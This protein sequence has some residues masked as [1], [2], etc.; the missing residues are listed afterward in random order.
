MFV[1]AAQP[2]FSFN[3]QRL[4]GSVLQ[5]SV[6]Y[7]A[8]GWFAGWWVHNFELQSV[9]SITI[10]P[11]TLGFPTAQDKFIP[12]QQI[13]KYWTVRFSESSLTF[14]FALE[15]WS[16][17]TEGSG[18][19]TRVNN[20]I[21]E[22]KGTTTG[23]DT[24]DA[25]VNA[26]TG[27][28]LSFNS[29][30]TGMAASGY[31][32]NGV[33]NFEVTKPYVFG[34]D[35]IYIRYGDNL[36]LNGATYAYSFDGTKHTWDGLFEITGNAVTYIGNTDYIYDAAGSEWRN[37]GAV[38]EY[39]NAHIQSQ[40]IF[41]VEQD[42]K[43]TLVGGYDRFVLFSRSNSYDT[44]I[45]DDYNVTE[46]TG[47]DDVNREMPFTIR[48]YPMPPDGVIANRTWAAW[49][50]AGWR[51]PIWIKIG[52]KFDITF[53]LDIYERY[54]RSPG[55]DGSIQSYYMA[56]LYMRLKR[57][58]KNQTIQQKIDD[59]DVKWSVTVNGIEY[60]ESIIP[61]T[62][63]GLRV[64]LTDKL[65]HTE[66]QT[67]WAIDLNA[68]N[69]NADPQFP[70]PLNYKYASITFEMFAQIPTWLEIPPPPPKWAPP[71]ETYP[72]QSAIEYPG[73][74]DYLYPDHNIPA[75]WK[76]PVTY[77]I[78]WPAEPA[79][80]K[81][82]VI[83]GS[84]SWP[85][86]PNDWKNPVTIGSIAWPTTAPDG[87]TGTTALGNDWAS[88]IATPA[89]YAGNYVAPAD[90]LSTT[91]SYADFIAPLK[92]ANWPST[93]AFPVATIGGWNNMPYPPPGWIFGV[94]D[95]T[96]SDPW[97][98]ASTT[99][100]QLMA[101]NIPSTWPITMSFPIAQAAWDDVPWPPT[102][103]FGVA[104]LATNEWFDATQTY[105]QFANANKPAAWPLRWADPD[106]LMWPM[107]PESGW[108]PRTITNPSYPLTG[109]IN[110][111]APV[112]WT[113][114][115]PIRWP[116]AITNEPLEW[117]TD[118]ISY[119]D[120]VTA[121][122]PYQAAAAN[123]NTGGDPGYMWPN[124]P[125]INWPRPVV[126]YPVTY[127]GSN[128]YSYNASTGQITFSN[129]RPPDW[130]TFVTMDVKSKGTSKEIYIGEDQ[131]TPGWPLFGGRDYIVLNRRSLFAEDKNLFTAD[132]EDEYKVGTEIGALFPFCTYG[133]MIFI[134]ETTDVTLNIG[135]SL[136]PE[137]WTIRPLAN[138]APELTA[139]GVAMQIFRLDTN[140][141][142]A[143]SEKFALM[144]MEAYIIG[145]AAGTVIPADGMWL[146]GKL[147]V[148][149]KNTENLL[150][151]KVID[152]M[153]PGHSA[154]DIG[155]LTDIQSQVPQQY[156]L[157]YGFYPRW[158][159]DSYGGKNYWKTY[160]DF[161]TATPSVTHSVSLSVQIFGWLESLN[162]KNVRQQ[163]LPA[164]ATPSSVN[165]IFMGALRQSTFVP[166]NATGKDKPWAQGIFDEEIVV[167]Y[168]SE[169]QNKIRIKYNVVDK[170][171]TLAWEP[172]P[173]APWG[174]T[175]DVTY[176]YTPGTST[177]AEKH[178]L[179]IVLERRGD[180][181][182]QL[183][184]ALIL[185]QAG[186]MGTAKIASATPS[187]ITL[188]ASYG[189]IDRN[190]NWAAHPGLDLIS[191]E[192]TA[193]T[194][195]LNVT[196]GNKA[197]VM[198][199]PQG[200]FKFNDG[201]VSWVSV[202]SNS[203]TFIHYGVTYTLT[204]G[205][206]T[207]TRLRFLTT[208]I[209]D[210]STRELEA[211][212][213]ASIMMAVK[214]FW[215]NDVDVEN[216]WWIDSDH[217]LAL[218]KYELVLYEKTDEL[219]DWNGDRWR[220]L[221]RG[222]RGNFFNNEDLYYSVS[223]A[224]GQKPVLFKL[225]NQGTRIAVFAIADIEA[226]DFNSPTWVS[227]TVSVTTITAAELEAGATL[228]TSV[229]SS[230]VPVDIN[231]LLC[232]AKISSTAVNNKFMLGFALT[233]G[234]QQW[235]C[236]FNLPSIATYTIVN[237]YGHVGHKGDLTGG[238]YPSRDCD[239]TGFKGTM[240]PVSHFKD[241][242]DDNQ[243][244]G[245]DEKI[246]ASGAQ[247]W[248]V[249][250]ELQ[251]IVSHLEYV[252]GAH[253]PKTMPLS[254]NYHM[255]NE[256]SSHKNVSLFDTL[257]RA[258]SIV[259]LVTLG[260]QADA[261]S[262]A[263]SYFSAI[264]MP[265]IWFMQP[266]MGVSVF[267]AQ[268]LHQA[269]YVHRNALPV[270]SDDGK[271]DKDVS[272]LR[273]ESN[274]E[275]TMDLG[276]FDSMIVLL[277]GIIGS[278]LS[279]DDGD[280]LKV[281]ASKDS[282]TIDD[283]KGRKLGQQATQAIMDGIATAITAKGLVLT[284][285][286]KTTEILAL[287]MFYTIND[288]AQ[289]WAGPGF[290]NHNFIG[291]AVSQGVSAARFKLT[292]FGAYFPLP[293]ITNLLLTGQMMLVKLIADKTHSMFDTPGGNAGGGL[294]VQ[295]PI[296]QIAAIVAH[297]LVTGADAL[298]AA[299]EFM[300][301]AMPDLYATMGNVARGF[302]SGGVERNTIEP[303]A[304]HTYG[305]KPMSMFWPA[306][307]VD[308]THRNTMTAEHVTGKVIW[309]G[310]QINVGGFLNQNEVLGEDH[311]DN[312]IDK[313]KPFFHKGFGAFD[314]PFNGRIFFPKNVLA[315]TCQSGLEMPERMAFVEGI[316]NML[317]TEGDLKNLQV[318]CCDY[319]FP[320]PPIHDY[321]IS[322]DKKIGVQAAN[323]EIIAYSMDETKLIDGPASNIIEV[324]TFF[325]IAS[326]YTAIEVKQDYDADYL[327]PWAITP[328]CIALN[329][330]GINCV[331]MA[332]AYHGFDGQFNR[333][334]SW[335]GGHG[336]DSATMVQQYAL[337]VNDH[338][339]R[340]NI[341][342]PSEFF[343]L[344]NGPP[345]INMRSYGKDRVASQV[346]DLTRQK[347]L[348]IN[349]PGEDR[350]L[351]RY[352]VPVHSE[353]LST[354][355]AVV[356]MLA[357]YKLHV[358][359]GITSLTTDV[360]NTQT[361]YKAPSS[362]DFNLYDIMYRATEEYIALLTLQDGI[363]AVEDKVPSAGLDFIGAT[364]KEAFFYSP[365]TRM[366]YSFSG[367]GD[368]TKRDIFNRFKSIR[369]GRWDFVNQEVV[370]KCLLGDGQIFD[371]DVTGDFV[372]RLDENNVVGELYP[373]NATIYNA[374]SD[375]KIL[376]MAGGLIYQGPKRCVV[377]RFVITDD[378][379][380]QIKE[381]KRKWKKLD[382]EVWAPGRDYN[383]TYD[384][385]HTTAPADAVYGWTHNAFRAATAMLGVSEETDCLFEWELTFAWTEQV[386]KIF[387]QNEFISFN[388]AGEAIGQ[389]GT[390]LSRPTHIFLYKELFKD[391]YYS[392]RY[393]AK[394]GSAN[395]ERLYMWGD[396]MVA[397]ESLS[398]YT[399][400][401]TTKRT[402][403]IATSQVDVQE[404]HEQ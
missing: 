104:G 217:V 20:I 186:L 30:G 234:M 23:G 388:V 245:P 381:N 384:D 219:D 177:Q 158:I 37:L 307:G 209:R 289:C 309:E 206:G 367:G 360:R 282:N 200:I 403:P 327:R 400:E 28:V 273:K 269:A 291:Q 236:I 328:T 244:E 239:A 193:T 225:Q 175:Y 376:S 188:D 394:N 302:Y 216:F 337:V 303:E 378:M 197:K 35:Y 161:H 149:Y 54:I 134:I 32:A 78:P 362:V 62:G 87:W 130:P 1:P 242:S 13:K 117:Y 251:N 44:D 404:L 254:N 191:P 213:T 153:W 180:F 50:I 210:N 319:T 230:L 205:P 280:N 323:G 338:F 48:M 49:L 212:D 105:V 364:T 391:G 140:G 14:Q 179:T 335:K 342:P 31:I 336:L 389:G 281:E 139:L 262:T 392:M 59:F 162:S 151:D 8:D 215:S 6:R 26:Y 46:L 253:V 396:G 290:V 65:K 131:V 110:P 115:W 223:S 132:S 142:A 195:R 326:S 73:I 313:N 320:A 298:L 315:S 238:Q 312:N 119:I 10:D 310:T 397:L 156:L 316:V 93:M 252:S 145:V 123:W 294:F 21:V 55:L 97:F 398:L 12:G 24:F 157:E 120:Y 57:K 305:N 85:V 182:A 214:Q 159:V 61:E 354:L 228:S 71:D 148:G 22:I 255:Q 184:R 9:G 374:R 80:W 166:I 141:G 292:R 3:R 218:T 150:F 129:T 372:A 181:Y 265:S 243:V 5:N 241:K 63:E 353:M 344:F 69:R 114:D 231:A 174:P 72:T 222:N 163:G 41:E 220:I 99:P 229:I 58:G 267:S 358:V 90:W 226:A 395:R 268:G 263:L 306:F 100:N 318:N 82:P 74:W 385:W 297:L 27:E 351:T 373:P 382:R 67:G 170:T 51:F 25:T 272:V 107:T 19:V 185:A 370:F 103:P 286:T 270:K 355:P 198:Y 155:P 331:Q 266:V 276:V 172:E 112:E 259:D 341:I 322:E 296:T 325:G 136:A 45:V 334:L 379:V 60:D 329:L 257:P 304:T 183:K 135:G 247:I 299:Y 124:Q 190:G 53:E 202:T 33:F 165:T 207:G 387:E 345:A 274:L 79:N 227:T 371:D 109:I 295:F 84:L 102:W 260:G 152:Y 256:R 189:N 11:T 146:D 34:A 106:H 380:P 264:V 88:W 68:Y 94:A 233:R 208:D 284:V 350:D 75:N 98:S 138:N 287:S 275:M 194:V 261:A 178:I 7:E 232:E 196:K 204:I 339:K 43:A 402:Q 288:G 332:K 333:I 346:M 271:S 283:T 369:N 127:P 81:N 343:G 352:A 356:R 40:A 285:K 4:L 300:K 39:Y 42:I 278:M 47:K 128:W 224:F 321:V 375:Y 393:N 211:L 365:A 143:S 235:T 237:G 348:D 108:V 116:V 359:E 101:N 311:P 18:T 250:S 187:L 66:L 17:W 111:T 340:S 122:I 203:I 249:Y 277:L 118:S 164:G 171:I 279:G 95:Y 399:K 366:Y 317:P 2:K 96:T 125:P 301:D 77:P 16:E 167:T 248:F 168:D 390:L 147:E 70:L 144:T 357:P 64:Q 246:F 173:P 308:A 201:G 76:N 52:Q 293:F 86:K 383:W 401:V 89:R 15:P 154:T 377:N 83:I 192:R 36:V 386:N 221:K 361:K 126:P 92:P 363:V 169:T 160:Y 347:G 368:I 91:I 133:H 29:S 330:N 176:E 113:P 349:I 121:H 137:T 240:Y 324:G 258:F 38:D 199:V 56:I 314:F